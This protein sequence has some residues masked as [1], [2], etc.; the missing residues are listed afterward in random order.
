VTS[1]RPL[2][3]LSLRAAAPFALATTVLAA[4]QRID[5]YL[6]ALIRGAAAAGI[7]GA[8]YRFQDVN[9]LLP[10]ALGQLA[11]SE[12]AGKDPRT[13][14]SIGKRIGAQALLSA[15]LP[16]A[17]FSILAQAMLVFLFGAQFAAGGPIVVVLML[18][19]LPGAVAIALQG[20]TAVSDPR[21]FAVTTGASLAINVGANLLLIPLF[22][23]LGAAVANVLSQTFLAASYYWALWRRTE[24]LVR[25]PTVP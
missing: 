7:Y 19:T 13:R 11:L 25:Q 21:R 24:E 16:A 17:V 18:S 1:D 14:M 8:S 9:M 12:A 5:N 15:L 2:P 23:G 10:A 4:Y 6:V 3:S 20:L 22:S